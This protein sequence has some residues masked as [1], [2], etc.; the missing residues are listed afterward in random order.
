MKRTA[1]RHGLATALLVGTGMLAGA[2]GSVAGGAAG[3]GAQPASTHHARHTSPASPPAPLASP[4]AA[5]P[6]GAAGC[7]STGLRVRVAVNQAG[8]AAGS[9]YY[10]IDFTNVSGSTCTLFGYPGVSFSTGPGGSQIGRAAGRDPAA[11]PMT[12]TLTAGAVAHATV[13]VAQA[14]NYSPSQ[15]KPVTAHWLKIYPPNQFKPLFTPFTTQA[16]AG[17]L[18]GAGD[19]L[20]IFAMRPGAGKRGQAP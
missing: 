11:P 9:V 1:A 10:P 2:C 19:Q 15:C 12:V 7:P 18:P 20:T 13:Q 8:G 3:Q 17:K 6:A 14:G 5:P 16:C 4:T